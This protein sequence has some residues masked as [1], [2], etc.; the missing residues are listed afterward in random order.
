MTTEPIFNQLF[1]NKLKAKIIFDPLISS[2]FFHY[3]SLKIE[4]YQFFWLRGEDP[5]ESYNRKIKIK[6][7]LKYQHLGYP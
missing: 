1:F 3:L 5:L 7:L 4:T 2:A 6:I